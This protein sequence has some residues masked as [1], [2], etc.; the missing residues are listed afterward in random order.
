MKLFN[1]PLGKFYLV[2]FFI[3][4]LNGCATL[5][6]PENPDDPYERFNRSMY[7][8]NET[9]DEYA[10]KPV[11]EGYKAITPDFVDTGITNFFNNLDDIVVIINDLLQFKFKQSATDISR[12]VIN[13]TIGI[14]GVFDVATKL[15]LPKHS[16]DFGQ[17]LGAWGINSGPYLVLPFVGPSSVRDGVGLAVDFTQFDVVFSELERE[18][19]IVAVGIKYIDIRADLLTASK[20]LND[21]APDPYAFLRDAWVLRRQNL[22]YDGSPPSDISDDELFEDDLFN[23]DIIRK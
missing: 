15:D 19:E 3:I 12:F 18:E 21:I 2:I 6:G 20:L 7:S 5:D 1:Q 10:Y 16:E 8:F 11:A 23:D 22:V 13:T 14:F 4:G 9:F 17:T